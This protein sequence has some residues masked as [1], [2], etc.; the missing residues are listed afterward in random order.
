MN[1]IIAVITSSH[2]QVARLPEGRTQL[3]LQGML[4]TLGSKDRIWYYPDTTEMKEKLKRFRISK[5][6]SRLAMEREKRW[7][8]AS[9]DNKQP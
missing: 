7:H 2:K 9:A 8:D 1:E 5:K 3:N 4:R 6:F